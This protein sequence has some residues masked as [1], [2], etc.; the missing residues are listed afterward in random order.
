MPTATLWTRPD[1][2]RGIDAPALADLPDMQ[3]WATVLGTPERED[4]HGRI[5]TQARCGERVLVESVS[6]D[7]ASV[8]LVD[9]PSSAD[10]RGYPG[11]L[12][13]S[14]LSADEISADPPENV[15]PLRIA[16]R[17]LGLEYLWGGL[18]EYGVDCS[19]LVCLAHRVAGIG[20]PRDA[21]DQAEAGVDVD[22]MH[23]EPG[24]ALFFGYDHGTGAI[25][26]VGLAYA[27]GYLLHAPKTGRRVEI[28]PL[29][30]P[31]YA[32]ELV[33]ARRFS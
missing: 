16:T 9:Q 29:S 14:H 25:H 11:W 31:G 15:P 12:R 2:P 24:D 4:L 10:S 18:S 32:D 1:A 33:A 13:R 5:L 28:C 27:P 30:E 26:H 17:F 3:R 21:H 23:P 8:F 20:I 22:P 19:G 6:G 7:W